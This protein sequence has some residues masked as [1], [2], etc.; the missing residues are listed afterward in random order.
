MALTNQ[1]SS[2]I[3]K[4][5]TK[6][7]TRRKPKRQVFL[8]TIFAYS[9]TFAA[10]LASGASYLYKNYTTSVL[11]NEVVALNAEINTFSVSDLSIVSEFNLTLQR[12][13]DRLGSTASIVSLLDAI[14]SATV[15]PAQITQFSVDRSGDQEMVLVASIASQSF[16]SA[17][18]QRKILNTDDRLFSDVLIEDV[19]L[20]IAGAD[21][22][23]DD[24]A[25]NIQLIQIDQPVSYTVTLRVPIDSLPYTDTVVAP[26]IIPESVSNQTA[27]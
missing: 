22:N 16:D 8:F 3:P 25:E 7:T 26:Q 13:A 24:T 1:Q 23:T 17:L 14:D 4:R 12:A 5:G 20:S 21:D 6:R 2:F 19:V 15:E 10:L 11:E 18:F 27:L 9:V